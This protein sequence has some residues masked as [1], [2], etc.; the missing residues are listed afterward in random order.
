MGPIC[1]ASRLVAETALRS[2]VVTRRHA[3]SINAARVFQS[4][5]THAGSA[6]VARRA[7]REIGGAVVSEWL[8]AGTGPG[9][10][11]R[12]ERG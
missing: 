2:I 7:H 11:A 4:P 12:S 9:A 6:G 1:G 5:L 3:T 8:S 10:G